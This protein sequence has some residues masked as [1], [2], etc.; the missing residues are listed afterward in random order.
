[1]RSRGLWRVLLMSNCNFSMEPTYFTRNSV[2]VSDVLFPTDNHTNKKHQL[3][4]KSARLLW[5]F[6][7]VTLTW[8]FGGVCIKAGNGAR[9]GEASQT[10]VHRLQRDRNISAALITQ[11]HEPR[12]MLVALTTLLL[13]LIS[14]LC[15]LLLLWRF[16]TF[17]NILHHDDRIQPSSSADLDRNK[18][19]Y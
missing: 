16:L 2:H 17:R 4:N 1:M 6:K 14:L 19:Q 13:L 10:G 5:H 18:P 8:A 11:R 12:C 9:S 7:E 3:E 15:E